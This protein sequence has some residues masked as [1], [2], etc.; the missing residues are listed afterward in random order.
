MENGPKLYISS[1]EKVKQNGDKSR[2][3]GKTAIKSAD[4]NNEIQLLSKKYKSD[5]I[6][7]HVLN[8]ERLGLKTNFPEDNVKLRIGFKSKEDD[9]SK[10]IINTPDSPYT[11]GDS[12]I[13][14]DDKKII[15]ICSAEN[16][17]PDPYYFRGKDTLVI[18]ST[19]LSPCNQGCQFCEQTN[20]PKEKQ[21]YSIN[22]DKQEIFK[23]V[24]KE[25]NLENLSLLKQI[26][27][28]TSC[29]GTEER[30]LLLANGYLSEARKI[31]FNGKLLFATNEIRS[32][33]GIK[34]LAELGNVIL[35]FT[36]ECFEN[37][38]SFMPG[39]KGAISIDEIKSILS[40]AMDY[41]I[42]TTFFYILGLDELEEMKKGFNNIKDSIS[43]IP[44]AS[45]FYP[46]AGSDIKQRDLKYYLDA[47]SIFEKAF[48]GKHI[49]DSK[50]VYRSLWP[51]S[52]DKDHI[53][54]WKK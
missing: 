52:N 4:I 13:S 28:V 12:E 17:S 51:L 16:D 6:E 32:E 53:M 50:Q 40:K 39:T 47:R 10:P 26:S 8:I 2:A 35:A 24:L 14:L 22:I 34:E 11:L 46:L 19:F 5:P 44:S 30:A 42:D 49:L 29:A 3:V 23:L 15:D 33:E 7:L 38:S 36:I 25:N 21:R 54:L 37:R 27:V 18:N 45:V 1:P 48:H 43:V 20:L 31:G 9:I 41:G